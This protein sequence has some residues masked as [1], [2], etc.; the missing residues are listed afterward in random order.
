LKSSE[1]TKKKSVP[2]NTWQ[3]QQSHDGQRLDF[4]LSHIEKGKSRSQVLQIIRT[5]LVRINRKK[6]LDPSVPV[7]TGDLIREEKEGN[8]RVITGKE[9]RKNFKIRVVYEDRD[10]I[11]IDKPAGVLSVPNHPKN[12]ENAVH[13]VKTYLKKKSNRGVPVVFIVHRLDKETSGLMIFARHRS[14]QDKLK[15]MISKYDIQRRY[16]AVALGKLSP[17]TGKL[18]G[19]L[20]EDKDNKFK[21]QISDNDEGKMAVTNYRVRKYLG[22]HSLVEFSLETGRTHQIRVQMNAAGHPLMGD[23]KYRD[24]NKKN[25][26]D[27]NRLALHAFQLKFTHPNTNRDLIFESPMPTSLSEYI[28]SLEK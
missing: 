13:Y 8:N 21:Q 9:W 11:V 24:T 23:S 19:L 14:I 20:I 18:Q 2:V 27:V 22:N 6:I 4:F 16:I 17:M 15:D 28:R 1:N 25:Q 10:F 5:G 3:V 7:H 26:Y 12:R